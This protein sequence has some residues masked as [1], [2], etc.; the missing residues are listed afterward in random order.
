MR[1]VFVV[2]RRCRREEKVEVLTDE[3]IL[4]DPQRPRG[5]VTC[6]H[7]GTTDVELRR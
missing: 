4:R 5:P 6:P 1:F 2:C 7:C 3:E